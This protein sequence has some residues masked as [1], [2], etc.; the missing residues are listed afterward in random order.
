MSV[1]NIRGQGVTLTPVSNPAVFDSR[2]TFM[3]HVLSYGSDVSSPFVPQPVAYLIFKVNDTDNVILKIQKPLN[4][5][6]TW[7]TGP[8]YYATN[9]CSGQADAPAPP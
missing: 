8:L 9:N 6:L 4:G 3:G 5:P 2:G 7:V 1:L